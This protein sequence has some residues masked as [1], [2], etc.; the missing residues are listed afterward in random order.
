MINETHLEFWL[1]KVNVSEHEFRCEV[2]LNKYK[3]FT[4]AML[5]DI[6]NHVYQ[7]PNISTFRSRQQLCTAI[8]CAWP[9]HSTPSAPPGPTLVPGCEDVF[10]LESL[11]GGLHSAN[12]MMDALHNYKQSMFKN[13]SAIDMQQYHAFEKNSTLVQHRDKVQTLDTT[14]R[15]LRQ[16]V[17]GHEQTVKRCQEEKRRLEIMLQT[18]KNENQHIKTCFDSYMLTIPLEVQTVISRVL[19]DRH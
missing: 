7:L 5:K 4:M 8:V 6:A 12:H 11:S 19:M 14:I 18:V 2:R 15:R 17:S 16:E 3:S 13:G 1:Q 10:N 9:H